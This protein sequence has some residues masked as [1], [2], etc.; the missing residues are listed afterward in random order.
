MKVW[1]SLALLAAFVPLGQRFGSTA[2]ETS[3]DPAQIRTSYRPAEM[4]CCRFDGH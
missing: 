3:S 1:V 4:S 2:A